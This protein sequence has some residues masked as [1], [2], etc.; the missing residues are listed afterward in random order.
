[1]GEARLDTDVSRCYS[2]VHGDHPVYGWDSSNDWSKVMGWNDRIDSFGYTPNDYDLYIERII[3]A[4][5][6][7]RKDK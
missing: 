7:A 5:D 2:G 6:D 3:D 4:A 1:M